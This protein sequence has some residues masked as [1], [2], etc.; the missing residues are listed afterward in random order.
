MTD[1]EFE[2][3]KEALEC[4]AAELFEHHQ[5][6]VHLSLVTFQELGD[7]PTQEAR[8]EALRVS[9]LSEL[10][11]HLFYIRFPAAARELFPLDR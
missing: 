3:L 7:K 9:R 5:R 4:S 8:D 1:A 2:T 6:A 10:L 11:V